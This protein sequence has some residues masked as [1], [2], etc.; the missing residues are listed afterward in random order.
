[1]LQSFRENGYVIVPSVLDPE[2]CAS[3]AERVELVVAEQAAL[4][5]EQKPELLSTPG[6]HNGNASPME[7]RRGLR[8]SLEVGDDL[9]VAWE[10]TRPTRWYPEHPQ[11]AALSRDTRIAALA[12]E[13]LGG[14]AMVYADQ[15]F[16][17]PPGNGGPRSLHQDN[18][19][20]GLTD[21]ADVLTAWIALDDA[22]HENGALRYRSGTHKRGVVPHTAKGAEQTITA[23]HQG[24]GTEVVAAVKRGGVVF[25]HGAAQH[26]SGSNT[27]DR[28][29]RAYGIHYIKRGAR[30]WND[31]GV[32]GSNSLPLRALL[33]VAG[34]SDND[35]EESGGGGDVIDPVIVSEAGR[36]EISEGVR[37]LRDECSDGSGAAAARL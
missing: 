21:S 25:H 16:L 23:G 28:P 20:F 22:D 8:S 19:Y 14:E 32:S 9:A 35:E 33:S 34:G 7:E 4:L 1:M 11:F 29:R 3:L 2:E 24:P 30:F 17:K 6:R 15:A 12:S 26:A 27:S 5:R 13:L 31:S 37:G 36:I 10:L 18:W